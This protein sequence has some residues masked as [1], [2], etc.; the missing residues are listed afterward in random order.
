MSLSNK[1]NATNI[2]FDAP[3]EP[4]YKNSFG[5]WAVEVDA[6][7]EQSPYQ[8][9]GVDVADVSVF[10]NTPERL[11][12]TGQNVSAH[13]TENKQPAH[14]ADEKL[15][16]S[17]NEQAKDQ[18]EVRA[19][20]AGNKEGGAKNIGQMERTNATALNE[21]ETGKAK[22][23]DSEAFQRQLM[24]RRLMQDM[25]DTLGRINVAID[26]TEKLRKLYKE[27][28]LDYNNQEHIDLLLLSNMSREAIETDGEVAFD[29]NIE[30]WQENKNKVETQL[31][32]AENLY[33]RFKL[34]PDDPE[35]AKEVKNLSN[36]PYDKE[37]VSD[38]LYMAEPELQDKI[39]ELADLDSHDEVANS[40]E[41]SEG[42]DDWDDEVD[43]TAS[44]QSPA[45]AVYGQSFDAPDMKGHFVAAVSPDSAPQEVQAEYSIQPTTIPTIKSS[46]G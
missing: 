25:Q 22:D 42:W 41:S 44:I 26:A 14:K 43:N 30:R 8:Q 12:L 33:E 24:L 15:T 5:V 9:V 17:K 7:P 21:I 36:N 19:F 10:E 6:E 27:G 45:Q 34:N 28:K 46:L 40:T 18:D 13:T 4:E 29:D 38:L 23:K 3:E 32:D 35:I 11:S 39:R 16:P 37:V 31:N 20:H 1:F 2:V